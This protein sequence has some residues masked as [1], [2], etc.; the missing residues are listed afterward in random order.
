MKLIGSHTEFDRRCLAEL[1]RIRDK[2]IEEEIEF[3]R[4]LTK[5][6]HAAP[7]ARD[8]GSKITPRMR[9]LLLWIMKGKKKN[10]ICKLM[11]ITTFAYDKTKSRMHHLL[12]VSTTVGIVRMALMLEIVTYKEW[13]SAEE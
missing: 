10:D 6:P 9:E 2:Q 12:G 8:K 5:I 7:Y 13:M 3:L 1:R 4:V 11:G